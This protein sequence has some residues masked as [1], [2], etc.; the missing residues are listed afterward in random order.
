VQTLLLEVALDVKKQIIILAWA[1]VG[2]ENESSWRWFLSQLTD[3][4]DDLDVETTTLPSD[5]PRVVMW[6]TTEP[7][8]M[9]FVSFQLYTYPVE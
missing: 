9:K 6:V 1:I 7:L 8:A 2:P 3:A 4:I 5:V